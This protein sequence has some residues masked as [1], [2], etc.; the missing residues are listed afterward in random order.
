MKNDSSTPLDAGRRRFLHQLSGAGLA[1]GGAPWL[2]SCGG[3][4]GD[5]QDL[6][7]TESRT[8]Y[9]NLPGGPAATDYFLVAGTVNHKLVNATPAHLAAIR[10][11][12]PNLPVNG[13]THVAEQIQMS[14]QS[15][16]V[17]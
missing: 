14:G 3:S 8:Y 10:A 9:F 15:P 6:P 13:L 17:C 5:A 7:A 2:V 1:L 16:Q 4:G 11:D 12:I